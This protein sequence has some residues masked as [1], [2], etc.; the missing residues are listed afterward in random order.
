MH[1]RVR[2]CMLV[3]VCVC[4]CVSVWMG[5]GVGVGVCFCAVRACL[6]I[7]RSPAKHARRGHGY[8]CAYSTHRHLRAVVGG[9]FGLLGLSS[10]LSTLEQLRNLHHQD[11]HTQPHDEKIPQHHLSFALPP[12]VL[13]IARFTRRIHS[14]QNKATHCAEYTLKKIQ[15]QL[16]WLRHF[17]TKLQKM[18]RTHFV[19]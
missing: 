17:R 5:V 16:Q 18:K 11:A 12:Q 4:V 13:P 1:A 14:K 8:L 3:C 6:S 2:E 19:G 10:S 15:Q 7:M 9:T